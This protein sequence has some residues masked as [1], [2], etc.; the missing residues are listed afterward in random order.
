MKEIKSDSG[1]A[2]FR[3]QGEGEGGFTIKKYRDAHVI[4]LSLIHKYGKQKIF[5]PKIGASI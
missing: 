1:D 4:H 5:D 3:S 2:S